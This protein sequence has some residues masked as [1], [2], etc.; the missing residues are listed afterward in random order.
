[1][2]EQSTDDVLIIDTQKTTKSKRKKREKFI[3]VE[4]FNKYIVRSTI[5]WN[6]LQLDCIYKMDKIYKQDDQQVFNLTSRDGNIVSV[7]LPEF[8]SKKL[9]SI[10]RS[11]VTLYLKPYHSKDGEYRVEIASVPKNVCKKCNREFS[12]YQ[13]LWN[14]RKKFCN[15]YQN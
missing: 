9:S 1:M 6:E 12:S 11:N 5:T 7:F 13:S 2:D 4:M 3:S 10:D 8:V 14:H 15:N